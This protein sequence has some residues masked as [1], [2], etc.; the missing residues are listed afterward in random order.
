MEQTTADLAVVGDRC[1]VG[2]YAVLE[3]GADLPAAT[4]T[5]PFYTAGPDAR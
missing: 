4:V 1:R 3:P 5:G 2:P